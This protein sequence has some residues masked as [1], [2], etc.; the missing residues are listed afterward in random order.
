MPSLFD[1][2]STLV[3]VQGESIAM[4][5]SYARDSS[6]ECGRSRVRSRRDRQN[7]TQTQTGLERQTSTVRPSPDQ[8]I[9]LQ[10]LD[11][12]TSKQ[13]VLR[14]L[15]LLVPLQTLKDSSEDVHLSSLNRTSTIPF[16]PHQ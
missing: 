2:Y 12:R 5:P 16:H 3:G 13:L 10:G 6:Q 9:L 4:S 11:D 15:H 7:L 8:Y 1:I 14:L